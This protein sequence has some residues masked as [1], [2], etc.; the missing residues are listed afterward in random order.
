MNSDNLRG[1][2]ERNVRITPSEWAR[3][4]EDGYIA[5][6]QNGDVQTD[7]L[8]D[9]VDEW[10]QDMSTVVL[11]GARSPRK[12]GT[13]RA[14]DLHDVRAETVSAVIAHQAALHPDVMAF[15]TEVLSGQLLDSAAVKNWIRDQQ[16]PTPTAARDGRETVALPLAL[17]VAEGSND[18]VTHHA[19]VEPNGVLGRLRVV[20]ERLVGIY[21]WKPGVATLFILTDRTPHISTLTVEHTRRTDAVLNRITLT[22]D[23]AL[24]PQV[25]TAQ[26]VAARKAQFGSTRPRVLTERHLRLAAFIAKR[27]PVEDWESRLIEWNTSVPM[28]GWRYARLATFKRDA[29]LATTR[30]FRLDE[31]VEVVTEAGTWH[32]RTSHPSWWREPHSESERLG[33]SGHK[34]ERQSPTKKRRTKLAKKGRQS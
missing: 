23:P 29:V 33:A 28:R 18:V 6:F 20:S 26:Y 19:L 15:R 27:P 7:D 22:I 11:H 25:V 4:S 12:K 30:L 1:W 31:R 16:S 32:P 3:L 9:I 14:A 10:R 8:L 34:S 5:R 13:T 2:L 17:P 24:P 21:G